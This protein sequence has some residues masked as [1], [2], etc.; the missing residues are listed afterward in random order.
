MGMC[1]QHS[2]DPSQSILWEPLDSGRLEVLADVDND[3][4][5]VQLNFALGRRGE[6]NL[7]FPSFPSIRITVEVFLLT[8]FFPSGFKVDRHVLQGEALSCAVRQDTFGKLPDVPVPKK[9]NSIPGAGGTKSG[10][11]SE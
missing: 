10:E 3:G 4:P 2:V 7:F 5:E 9:M 11:L 8:F 1:N 6:T